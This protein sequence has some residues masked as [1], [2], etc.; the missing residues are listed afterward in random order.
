MPRLKELC[1]DHGTFDVLDL[2]G[3]SELEKLTVSWCKNLT[4]LNLSR[5]PVLREL[6]LTYSG[7]RRL[8]L[9]NRSVLHDVVLH[10]VELDERSV[11]YLHQVLEQNGGCIRKP[12]YI[13][14]E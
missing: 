2:S 4:A 14:E 9:H 10:G 1:C 5:N 13:D 11:K 7:V 3:N 6:E 12:S 8:G